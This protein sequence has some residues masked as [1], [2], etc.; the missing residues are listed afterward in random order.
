MKPYKT[1]GILGGMGP[2]ATAELYLR[3][4]RIF[5]KEYGAKYDDDFPEII[6]V[7]VPIPDVVENPSEEKIV[8]E[9]LVSGVKKLERA[10][11][12]FV[13]IPC[14]T[15]NFFF[16]E[17][18]RAVSIPVLSIL[19]EVANEIRKMEV[20]TVGLLGTEMTINKNIYN[21]SM[22]EISLISSTIEEQKRIT[23]III[24]V[25]AGKKKAL[26]KNFLLGL[27]DNLKELGAEKVIL[28]CTELPL[29]LK[30]SNDLVDTIDILAQAT[31]R[32]AT[33][34]GGK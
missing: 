11:A 6:I 15:V 13:V 23:K 22:P 4:I 27:I 32:K 16:R 20:K 33:I 8:Q 31:V 34:M 25:L 14:N 21:Q 5:Q 17:I 12:S 19:T 7:S 10:G 3:I 24:N 1:I 28:G 29:L 2:E 26:D 9:M 18:E 30:R